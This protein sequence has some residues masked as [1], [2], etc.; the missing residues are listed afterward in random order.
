MRKTLSL[1]AALLLISCGS[2]ESQKT[3]EQI[4]AENIA[5]FKAKAVT[6]IENYLKRNVSSDPDYGRVIETSNTSVNDSVYCGNMRIAVK[7]VFGAV[8]QKD[9]CAFC[10]CKKENTLYLMVWDSSI[11]F[12]VRYSMANGG[13]VDLSGCYALK[14]NDNI[15]KYVT[16]HGT[17]YQ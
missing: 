3:P 5:A 15:F 6:G 16:E 17:P 8:Q 12:Q 4:K 1:L 10:V 13:S 2:K 14:A 9:G 7:N 11:D